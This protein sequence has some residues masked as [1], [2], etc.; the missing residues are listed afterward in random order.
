MINEADK[1]IE[2]LN[3]SIR[4]N[5]EYQLY[6]AYKLQKEERRLASTENEFEVLSWWRQKGNQTFSIISRVMHSIL[7]IPAASAISECN[8]S[9][10]GNTLTNKHNRLQPYNVDQDIC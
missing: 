7:C 1:E 10:A 8:F 9:D 4:I 6:I 2:Q 5:I 3:L